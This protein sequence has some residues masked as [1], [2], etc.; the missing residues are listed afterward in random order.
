MVI[1]PDD[2]ILECDIAPGDPRAT[3]TWYRDNKE[4]RPG[5]KYEMSFDD[6]LAS[7]VVHDTTYKD[8][9]MYRCEAANKLGHVETECTLVV[10]SEY[11]YI[12]SHL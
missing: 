10:E 8:G 4:I 11:M 7:L 12:L 3:L 5:K 6:G 9:G 1:T 2:A